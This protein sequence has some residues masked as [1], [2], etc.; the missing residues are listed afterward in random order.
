VDLDVESAKTTPII[1]E[2]ETMKRMRRKR[3]E[4]REEYRVEGSTIGRIGSNAQ[5]L[6]DFC[7][8]KRGPLPSLG[9]M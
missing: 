1:S 7:S 5:R 4:K 6:R 8:T 2:G 9:S 3:A